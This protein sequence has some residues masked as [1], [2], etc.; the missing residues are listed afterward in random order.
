MSDF[1]VAL[2]YRKEIRADVIDEFIQLVSAPS[3][4]LNIDEREKDGPYA[5][6][7]WLLPTAVVI[8]ICKSYFDGF[9]KE[10]GKE[11]YHLLKRALKTL[12]KRVLGPA[13]PRVARV[14]SKGKV[15][16]SDHYSLIYSVVADAGGRKRIKLLIQRN[17]SQRECEEILDAFMDFLDNF[18]NK[19]PDIKLLE[20]LKT[21]RGTV[22]VAFNRNTK[23]IEQ[24]V[25]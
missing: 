19:T 13:G 1:D 10:M 25:M 9:L 8:F 24:V 17:V 7:E 6:L 14:T 16:Q 21:S 5:G 4:R 11:H 22:L 18:H 12:A 15:P 2:S 20:G 3:L 23:T